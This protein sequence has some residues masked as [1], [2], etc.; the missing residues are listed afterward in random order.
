MIAVVGLPRRSGDK[1]VSCG[2]CG[3]PIG[4]ILHF[5]VQDPDGFFMLPGGWNRRPVDGVYEPTAEALRRAA[6]NHRP[7]SG[8]T[9]TKQAMSPEFPL[10][11]RC[12]RCRTVNDVA[13]DVLK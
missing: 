3:W 2:S 7:R 5:G 1:P 11:L 4:S 8:R 10:R 12:S 13:S 6:A 9:D